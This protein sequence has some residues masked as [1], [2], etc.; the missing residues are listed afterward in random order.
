MGVAR[1]LLYMHRSCR[2][3]IIHC[4]IKPENILLDASF[5]PKIADFGVR[6]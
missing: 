4:D 2:G 1:G 6:W 3:C 5:V